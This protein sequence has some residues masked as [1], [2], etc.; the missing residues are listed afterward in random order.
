MNFRTGAKIGGD[1]GKKDGGDDAVHGEEGGVEAAQI[2]RGD[3]GM[4]VCQ[5][6][7]D[8]GDAEPAD[9]SELEEHGE[10]DEK[11][12]HGQMHGAGGEESH[13]NSY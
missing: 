13:R 12:K 3:E 6:K 7:S 5:Q 9:D 10:P 8:G 2:A 4:F 1:K 11:A